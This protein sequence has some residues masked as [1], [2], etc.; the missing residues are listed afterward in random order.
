MATQNPIEQEGTYPL[1]EAQLD[2][3]LMKLVVGYP[4]ETEYH[5]I[6]DR[7]TTDTE[8]K[9]E[10][11][12]NAKEI[13]A[14]RHTVR[15]VPVPEHVQRY[16]VRLVIGTQPGSEFAPAKVTENVV[17]GA[18]PRGAQS[19]LLCGKVRA[20]LDGRFAVSADDIEA[21]AHAVLRHRVLIGFQGQAAGVRPDDAVDAVVAHVRP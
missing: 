6:L 1:P 10:A 2:R 12:S 16:A 9:V 7:T 13:V 17:L 11:V 3:F 8:V 4:K 18:S 14:M 5:E 21:V 19:L 15:A 20:L